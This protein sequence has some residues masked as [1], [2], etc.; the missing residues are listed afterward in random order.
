M[1]GLLRKI[2]V[3]LF[4]FMIFG[5]LAMTPV[6]KYQKSYINTYR[7]MQAKPQLHLD[8]NYKYA[9]YI[10]DGGDSKVASKLFKKWTNDY[11][12]VLKNKPKENDSKSVKPYFIRDKYN[13]KILHPYRQ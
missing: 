7:K 2:W 8:A 1:H 11:S 10:D 5:L 6:D 3:V 12:S 4:V 13:S 9:D